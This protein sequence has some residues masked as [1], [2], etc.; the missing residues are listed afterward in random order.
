I[1]LPGTKSVRADLDY[2]KQQGW[3]KDIQRHLRLGGKVMGICGGYQMLGNIIHDP[4][5]VEGE[6]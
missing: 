3:D 2:L 5:G 4:D 6:P 1:I